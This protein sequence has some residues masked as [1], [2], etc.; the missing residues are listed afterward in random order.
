VLELS[1]S[2]C[3]PQSY[4][5]A[6]YGN[7]PICMAKTQYSLSTDAAAKGVPTGFRVLVRDVRAAVGAG[8]I[9]RK[10][11]PCPVC[12]RVLSVCST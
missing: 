7:L 3:V 4:T 5:K 11:H 2:H 10:L 12:G 9:Y 6:G 1:C 8:Y